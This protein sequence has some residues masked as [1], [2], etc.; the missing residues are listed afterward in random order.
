MKVFGIRSVLILCMFLLLPFA[1]REEKAVKESSVQPTEMVP[2]D[3]VAMVGDEPIPRA[4]LEAA[5]EALPDRKREALFMRTVYYLVDTKIYS[6]EARKM[7]LQEDP[8]VQRELEKARKELLAR[9]FLQERI[10]PNIEPSEQEVRAYYDDHQDQFVVPEGVEVSRIRVVQKK[11]A[12]QAM[13]EL[14]EGEPFPTVAKQ[15]SRLVRAKDRGKREW[16]YRKR[17]DPEL[18]KAAF[19]LG[20]GEVSDIIKIGTANEYQIVKV[21]DK[22]EERLLKFEDIKSKIRFGL[23]QQ[24]KRE[25][26]HDYYAKAGVDRNPGEGILV[27]IGDEVFKEDAIAPI[28]AKAKQEEKDKLRRRWIQY[29]VDTTV[30]SK[31]AEKVGLQD[32]P[33]IARKLRLK[34]DDVLAD[35]Y[36]K[37]VVEEKVKITDEDI[38][39][40]YEAH[41]DAFQEPLKLKLGLIVVATRDEAEDILK[42]VKG[43][44]P[45]SVLAREKSIDASSKKGGAIDWSNKGDLD[46]ALEAA[47]MKLKKDEVSDIVKTDRGY[48]LIKLVGK[49]GGQRPLEEVTSWIRMVLHRKRMEEQREQYYKKWDVRI[50]V[51]AP[52]VEEPESATDE[53][54]AD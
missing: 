33:K 9:S 12:E 6:E 16:L 53:E 31:E 52:E 30:F 32:D 7:G 37:R 19:K 46:P 44:E 29:F 1:C 18:E 40:E 43:G 23:M 50:L 41:L 42:R 54:V 5:L 10:E 27:K 47:A 25:M 17:I 48:E 28:L 20:V 51:K 2:E 4:D 38:S 11:H 14:K 3:A 21:L 24:K 8:Q 13:Q 15:W 45:F 34:E 35:A 49:R 22:S 39:K 26:I 36:R